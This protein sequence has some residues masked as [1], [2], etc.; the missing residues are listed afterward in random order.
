ME[1]V[2]ISHIGVD[3][4]ALER[5]V[6]CGIG[7]PHHSYGAG[8]DR[9]Q[10][11]SRRLGFE[12]QAATHQFFEPLRRHWRH[13]DPSLRS[14]LDR[15]FGREPSEGIAHR[16]LA[17]AELLGETARGDTDTRRNKAGDEPTA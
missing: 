5:R 13:D 16:H 9:R 17:H 3:V 14:D 2:I 11:Q 1:G 6:D 10:R 4:A 12:Q 15:T 7:R 8:V